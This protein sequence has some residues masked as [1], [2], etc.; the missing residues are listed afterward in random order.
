VDTQERFTYTSA[1]GLFEGLHRLN[2]ADELIGHN[3]ISYDNEVIAKLHR[4]LPKTIK[5]FDTMIAAGLI[6]SD[7]YEMDKKLIAKGKAAIPSNVMGRNSLESWGYRLGEHKG[8]YTGGWESLN[9]EM[10][11]YCEQ[12]VQVTYQLY[13]KILSKNYSQTALDMEM[14]VASIITR[15][16]Q[17]GF[18]FDKEAAIKLLVELHARE[19]ELHKELQA[20]F[21]PFY[22]RDGKQ[23]IPKKTSNKLGYTEGCPVTKIKITEFNPGSR[24]HI[25]DRLRAIHG[26]KPTEFGA[27]GKP[28]IDEDVLE[29]L[30]YPVAKLLVE[31][32]M[33]EKRLGQLSEGN[34]AWLKVEKNS[35]I[36]GRVNTVGTVTGR[37]THSSPNL[38]QV[39]ACG[40]PYGKECRALFIADKGWKLVGA[41]ASGLELRMLA[42]FLAR[43]DSGYYSGIVCEGTQEQGNDVHTVNQIAAGLE[44][45]SQAK[46]MVYA[47]LYGAGAAKL[48][49]IVG[50]GAKAGAKLRSKF[51][52]GLPAL[53]KL[54]DAVQK[55]AGKG[56]LVGL[57]GREV[58]V[59]SAHA[60]LNTLLQSA[61]AI[62]M[63]KALCILE[64]S[65]AANG[66]QPG[67][68][69]KNV[70]NCH[71]E[72]GITCRPEI[73]DLIGTL[74]VESIRKAGEFFNMRCPLDGAYK[75]GN[76]WSETH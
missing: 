65:L 74:A 46:T 29:S 52:A 1:T 25:G 20:H 61:G 2:S 7:R 47:L 59:R 71:D 22:K 34:Q 11:A 67:I 68:D 13:Q 76:N 60:A 35:R 73:A 49:T 38:A 28:T 32:L 37:M 50:G 4:R 6:W 24:D 40:A 41:D 62:V 26:W 36:Y 54:F 14:Q 57:D 39:P 16:E 23:F 55:A 31:Y 72:Y 44:T 42:H 9:D 17:F 45:R 66:L 21:K 19:S 48:G 43:W 70:L 69:Y 3:I 27:D 63:K 53:G 30:K 15:Q 33:I 8:D 5:M 56:Y 12:D 10:I 51:L 18:G 75:I 64:D 58:K